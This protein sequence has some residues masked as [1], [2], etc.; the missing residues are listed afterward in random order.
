MENKKRNIAL[1][2][3]VNLCRFILATTFLFSGFVKANDPMGT[4]YKIQEY[5]EAWQWLGMVN[6]WVPYLIAYGMAIVEFTLGIYMLFGIRKRIASVGLLLMMALMTPLTLWLAVKNPISDCGCFG[7]ALVLTNWETF[8]KNVVLLLA[9]LSVFRW[10]HKIIK[11]VSPRVDWLV[12]LYSFVY[13]IFFVFY[14]LHY[15]PVFDFRP[16]HIGMNIAE[17][18]KIPE[19]EKPTTYE[20]RFIYEKEGVQQEFGIDNFPTD[21]TWTF[22]DSKTTVKEKG[23]EPPIHDFS[24]VEMASGEDITDS[25]LHG[26][27]YTFLLVSPWLGKADDSAMDEINS[28]YDY[29]VEHHYRF[30]CVTASTEKEIAQWQ[31]NTGAEYP[32]AMMDAITL[33]TMIRTNPGLMLLKDG[34]I[35][36]K[37]GYHS[38]PSESELA[39]PLEK[40]ALGKINDKTFRRKMADVILLFI[41]PLGL[42]TLVDLLWLGW[43]IKRRNKQQKQENEMQ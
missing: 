42:L 22:V 23:Y 29:S 27:G 24:V 40:S 9:A 16:Y 10:Q 41:L 39:Q 31:E 13:I 33:K 1:T 43:K 2:V 26:R 18:M 6:G 15:L 19:G 25:I 35:I 20:T 5:F 32:F 36:N 21:S 8:W 3:W 7:D 14:T 11:L 4:V 28:I 12:S 38:L 30:L 34:T 37:W 17:G